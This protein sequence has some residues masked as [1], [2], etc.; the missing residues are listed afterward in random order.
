MCRFRSSDAWMV[1]WWVRNTASRMHSRCSWLRVMRLSWQPTTRT[2]SF[3]LRSRRD[4]EG[5]AS[6]ST[7][8]GRLLPHPVGPLVIRVPMPL[9]WIGLLCIPDMNAQMGSSSSSRYTMSSSVSD[10][11]DMTSSLFT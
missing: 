5:P 1:A 8:T 2:E 7:T 6:S 3:F 4:T 10:S 11:R 9:L